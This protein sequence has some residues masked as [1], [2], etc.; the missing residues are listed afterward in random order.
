M[1]LLPV[2]LD[3]T[4][5]PAATS[6]PG[7]LWDGGSG[8]QSRLRCLWDRRFRS[9]CSSGGTRGGCYTK[10]SG[11]FWLGLTTRRGL[12][13]RTRVWLRPTFWCGRL[14]CWHTINQSIEHHAHTVLFICCFWKKGNLSNHSDHEQLKSFSD[15]CFHIYL[16]MW[17]LTC[18]AAVR[19]VRAG[20]LE[21]TWKHRFVLFL[22][23]DILYVQ[24]VPYRID[25][26][27]VWDVV[28]FCFISLF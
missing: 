15:F 12:L 19:P 20:R 2:C 3:C 4:C 13:W 16:E 24:K 6:G 5:A 26:S 28:Q 1:E 21:E 14:G 7:L 27:P 10:P 17:R 8:S 22:W 25:V 18:C 9:C 23:H 11:H